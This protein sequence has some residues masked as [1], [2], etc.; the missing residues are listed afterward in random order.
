MM[1]GEKKSSHLKLFF[2]IGVFKNFAIFTG[3]HYEYCKRIALIKNIS[4]ATSG[5]INQSKIFREVTGLK[6][7]EQH[8]LYDVI[9][10][11]VKLYAVQLKQKST[12][13]VSN[14]V[15]EILEQLLWRIIFWGLLLK[16]KQRRRR[17][18]SDPCG[19]RFSLFPRRYL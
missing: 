18:R 13:G 1:V 11:D 9:S 14:K 5:Y 3:K 16:R 4:E 7:Q 17:T 6:F 2:Q 8:I 19:F 12:A 10:V 15:C